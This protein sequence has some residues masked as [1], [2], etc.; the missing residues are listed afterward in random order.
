VILTAVF[1]T[2]FG[3]LRLGKLTNYVTEPV[4]AGFLN[5][6]AMFLVKSQ[7]CYGRDIVD[8]KLL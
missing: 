3:L 5:A 8:F 1:E 6:F 2:I 4:V 7:V